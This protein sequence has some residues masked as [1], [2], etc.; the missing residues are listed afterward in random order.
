MNPQH[1]LEQYARDIESISEG[2]VH[3][4]A[5]ALSDRSVEKSD[6]FRRVLSGDESKRA[7]RLLSGVHNE[8]FVS[9]R[10]YLRTILGL[11]LDTQPGEIRFEYNRYGKP[12]LH[13]EANPKKITFNL[14]HSRSLALCAVTVKRDIGI[15]VEYPRVVL[16]AEKILERFFSVGERDYY[17]AQ[18]E[19][20]KEHTFMNLWTIKEAYSKALGRGLSSVL[21]D[22]DFT[23]VFSSESPSG[24]SVRLGTG[25]ESIWTIHRLRPKDEYIAALALKG[26]A[27]EIRSFAVPAALP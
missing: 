2:V 16:R 1:E 25:T 11:Y 7:T 27:S 6:V 3:V 12:S 20:L 8:R 18:P 9:A 13:A 26:E 24:T 5:I 22:V 21:R 14:S 4:W 19:D 10:Y 17:L 23:Q 15:D